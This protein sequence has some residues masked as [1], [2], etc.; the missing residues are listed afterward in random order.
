[1]KAIIMAGGK[2]ERLAPYNT[3]LPKVLMPV[4]DVPILEI[5]IRQ[6]E[7]QKFKKIF[8]ATGYLSELITAYFGQRGKSKIN[9]S[10]VKEGKPLGTFGAV[11][12]IKEFKKGTFFVMN[13]DILT[14]LN[15][16][17]VYEFHK[18]HNAALTV[19]VKNRCVDIDY[20]VIELNKDNCIVKH[21]EKPK[22][23]LF[24]GMGIYV[25]EPLV[26][27]YI[28]KQERIDFPCLLNRLIADGKKVM[29]YPS[30]DY[31]MDIGRHDDY[32]KAV[33]D[34]IGNPSKF[35]RSKFSKS[36]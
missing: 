8:V 16:N 34:F 7:S 5:I 26:L 29:A 17:R 10:F 15:F 12:L 32:E 14:T 22:I 27:S 18:K 19:A 2:G 9:L 13:G 1:M 4:G 24:V 30:K 3:I 21:M 6:L 28:K 35:V 33:D 36:R 20:G 31:W 25:A 11:A 23:D